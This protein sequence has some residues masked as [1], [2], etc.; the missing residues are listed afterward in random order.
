[1]YSYY[2]GCR[3]AVV[4]DAKDAMEWSYR[5]EGAINLVL[6]YRGI[7]PRFA[8]KILRIQKVPTNGCEYENGHPGLTVHEIHLW[9]DV[10][11]LV[12]APTRE[13]AEHFFVQQ[14]M[15]PFLGPEHVDA[16]I[17]ILVSREFLEAVEKNVLH[18]RP[19][20]RVDA[21]KLNLLRD[22][23]LLMSDHSI[24]PHVTPKEELCICVEIKPKC[25]FLP[26]SKFIIE[27][28]AVKR[29]ITRFKM[30]QALKLHQ[31]K[32]SYIS[33][34]DPLDMFSGSKDRLDKAIKD[35]FM[36]P[37]NNFRVFV[38]GCLIF[39]G[40]GGG[41]EPTNSKAGQAFEDALKNI[42][43]AKE[44]MR[45]NYFLEL[46]SEA[47]FSSGLLNRLLEVQKL[48]TFDI[49]GAIH[50]YYNV[51]SQPCV[52]CKDLGSGLSKRFNTLHS[53]S[54]EESWKILRDY[55]IAATAKDLSMMISFRSRED[56]KSE[57]SYGLVSLKSTNQTFDYK[58]S[59]ID[60]DLKPLKKMEFYYELDKKIVSSYLT[61]V[62]SGKGD[63]KFKKGNDAIRLIQYCRRFCARR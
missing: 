50:V 34:Y 24:F 53:I 13:I 42:I 1:M 41:A 19:T 23:I 12:S 15:C 14:V 45:T 58:A 59:F 10:K 16:G 62:N 35:L 51:I 11:D 5:G 3:M 33:A 31:G 25:G 60:L 55:L 54:M 28:N 61:M 40:L 8:G 48:D 21:A 39:G 37:Q 30:H 6:S 52:V 20:W 44:G 26:A 2:F 27:S 56:G 17:H 7:A 57:S 47:V 29:R 9:K 43:F 46:I 32:I 22:S 38:N 4:L 36:T 49:E 63:G 18:K